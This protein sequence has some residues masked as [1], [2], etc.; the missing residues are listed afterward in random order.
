MWCASRS[1]PSDAKHRRPAANRRGHPGHRPRPV[2]SRL[3]GVLGSLGL[4]LS[5]A[6]GGRACVEHR[7][8][9]HSGASAGFFTGAARDSELCAPN[10]SRDTTGPSRGAPGNRRQGSLRAREPRCGGDRASRSGGALDRCQGRRPRPPTLDDDVSRHV[11][12]VLRSALVLETNSSL[13]LYGITVFGRGFAETRNLDVLVA[14]HRTGAEPDFCRAMGP[15]V[16]R[17]SVLPSSAPT[18][19]PMRFKRV[20]LVRGG[21]ERESSRR[22]GATPCATERPLARRPRLGRRS[23]SHSMV[24][25]SRS[26]PVDAG[27][28]GPRTESTW[29]R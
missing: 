14:G 13:E 5:S 10:V 25:G 1:K 28:G 16:T 9:A 2:P 8:F 15:M 27:V 29:S 7:A 11:V 18:A 21:S 24:C 20:R 22:S 4:T 17:D 12:S 26:E 3:C 6:A 23:R 19:A